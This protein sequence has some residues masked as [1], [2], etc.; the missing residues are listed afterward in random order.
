MSELNAVE[1]KVGDLVRIDGIPSIITRVSDTGI[2]SY[3]G[4]RDGCTNVFIWPSP[5]DHLIAPCHALTAEEY[6]P[7]ARRTL[8]PDLVG[9]HP[10]AVK[11]RRMYLTLGM[12][13]EYGEWCEASQEDMEGE[14]GD[15]LWYLVQLQAEGADVKTPASPPRSPLGIA[16]P[17]ETIKKAWVHGK[18]D[19]IREVYGWC[20][21]IDGVLRTYYEHRTHHIRA[22]NIAKLARRYPQG[23]VR[24]G[25]ER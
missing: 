17:F 2:W 25:G 16:T 21:H 19:C 10:A 15:V 23:F 13:G 3:V 7:L 22:R 9:D 12:L 6:L 5:A 1:L 24:G 4:H 14:A 18:D 20:E 8:D 11:A